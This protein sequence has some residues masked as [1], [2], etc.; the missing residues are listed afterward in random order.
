MTGDRIS[1]HSVFWCE[2]SSR[3]FHGDPLAINILFCCRTLLIRVGRE[4]MVAIPLYHDDHHNHD[5]AQTEPK[6]N[7]DVSFAS[8]SVVNLRTSCSVDTKDPTV[9]SFSR[10]VF[11][12]LS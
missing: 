5:E 7:G 8:R 9:V 1:R 3:Y 4:V 10:G 12:D 6:D 2:L 11:V